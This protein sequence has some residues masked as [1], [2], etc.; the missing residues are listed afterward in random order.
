MLWT[1]SFWASIAS[2][3][4]G[5]SLFFFVRHWLAKWDAKEE[6]HRLKEQAET[7]KFIDATLK[8]AERDTYRFQAS[9]T[10]AAV[11]EEIEFA[12]LRRLDRR[13]R[14]PEKQWIRS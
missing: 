8:A 13:V 14:W 4:F 9:S 12:P 7:S 3:G 10:L 6:R 11:L 2:A 5:V 1:V